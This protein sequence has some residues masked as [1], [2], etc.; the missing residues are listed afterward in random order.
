MLSDTHNVYLPVLYL[1]AYVFTAKFM[2]LGSMSVYLPNLTLY[3]VYSRHVN[4]H[5]HIQFVENMLDGR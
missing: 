3:L 2:G 4:T 1:F 5:T